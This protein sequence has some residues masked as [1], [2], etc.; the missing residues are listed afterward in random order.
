MMMGRHFAVEAMEWYERHTV[1]KH[2]ELMKAGKAGA[3][4]PAD[5][6]LGLVKTAVAPGA[7]GSEAPHNSHNSHHSHHSHEQERGGED[8]LHKLQ[9]LQGL[10]G[11]PGVLGNMGASCEANQRARKGWRLTR[12][13]MA[14]NPLP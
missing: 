3:K 12:V 7:P 10:Q 6:I 13:S 4:Q 5:L 14:P 8:M 2:H 1:Q 11:L 9:G